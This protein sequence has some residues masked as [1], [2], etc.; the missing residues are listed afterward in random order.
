[1]TVQFC[2]I[3]KAPRPRAAERKVFRKRKRLPGPK[4]FER[5]IVVPVGS[6]K[7]QY[8][9]SN[10]PALY[11]ILDWATRPYVRTIVLGKGIQI[12]GTLGFYGLLLREGEYT[13]DNALVVVADERTL[14]KLI[15]KRLQKMIDSSPSLAAIKSANPDETTMYSVTLANGFTID[16]AW[17]SSETS[18][19]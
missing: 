12:G 18:V 6:R 17:A 10:N 14:K 8:R 13:A 1:M 2:P 5:N 4:W 11:S 16:G 9:N 7:G 3:P 15:K 19:S